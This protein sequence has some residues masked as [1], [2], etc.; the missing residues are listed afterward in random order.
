[1]HALQTRRVSFESSGQQLVGV[2][3]YTSANPTAAVVLIHGMTNSK[4]DC[5]LIKETAEALAKEGLLA[6]R[7][8]SFGSG[9]SPGELA[10]RTISAM[11]Q[12][13]RDAIEFI[14]STWAPRAIGLW[15]R[16]TGGTAAILCSDCPD[17]KAFGLATTPVLLTEVFVTRFEKVRSLEIE[18]EKQGKTLPGTGKYKGEFKFNPGFFEE[19]SGYERK[20][21]ES[22]SKMSHVLVLGTTPDTKVPLNNATTIVNKVKE[23]KE[24]HI[25]EHVDHDYKGVEREAV[26]LA[27]SWF[28]KYLKAT[29]T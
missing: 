22:L 11:V 8:D 25:F 24:I 3:E 18:L 4:D 21:M 23:P 27:T 10:D 1:M 29:A 28:S 16:S 26:G 20:V 9:E 15:G 6:F 14:R 12:N 5:P 7:F 13:T 2:M 19:M 17:V